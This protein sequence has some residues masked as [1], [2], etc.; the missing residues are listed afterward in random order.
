MV[1]D[2]NVCEWKVWYS[3]YDNEDD[4]T[5]EPEENLDCEDKIVEF[6]AKKDKKVGFKPFIA[7]IWIRNC[8]HTLWPVFQ[9]RWHNRT[10]EFMSYGNLLFFLTWNDWKD[11]EQRSILWIYNVRTISNRK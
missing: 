10:T 1:F 9:L 11:F 5:W 3:G 2:V 7:G 8:Y 6:N 4:N